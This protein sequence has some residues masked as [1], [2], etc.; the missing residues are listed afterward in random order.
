M[1]FVQRFQVEV[2]EQQKE[3]LRSPQ[4]LYGSMY[5]MYLPTFG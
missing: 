4:D 5:G 3:T 2:Q 1:F